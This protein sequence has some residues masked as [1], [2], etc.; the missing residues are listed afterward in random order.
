[1]I[2]VLVL[3]GSTG[4]AP[5]Q[6]LARLMVS[7]P[8]RA[9]QFIQPAPRITLRWAPGL[10]E[11][12][13]AATNT[14]GS[15]PARLYWMRVDAATYRRELDTR[16]TVKGDRTF[17][18]VT[19]RFR[20]PDQ[21]L[22]TPKPALG[23][24]FLIHGYAVDLETLFPLALELADAGWRCL[25]VDLRGHGYSNGDRVSFGVQETRDLQE[26]CSQLEGSGEVQGPYVAIGHS[27][28]GAVALRWQSVDPGVRTCVALGAPARFR[29]GVERVRAAYSPW[30]PRGWV[31]RAAERVPAVLAVPAAELDTVHAVASRPPHG[32]LIA[33]TDDTVAPPE[34]AAE[35]LTHLA[36]GSRMLIV[37][38]PSHETL[39]YE[40][41]Q[42][43]GVLR[44]WLLAAAGARSPVP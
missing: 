21:G 14:V 16:K 9:P 38:G 43:G 36:P 23:T 22:P 41:D 33:S 25:L 18:E 7:P 2:A 19:L 20:L 26:L 10:I 8:N 34:D 1:M 5:T 35:L 13:P 37:G 11:R 17:G 27:L 15:P 4:C 3:V 42:F 44:H 40:L 28:G 24:A 29:P 12:F 6:T 32:L 39:P 30:V 31:R